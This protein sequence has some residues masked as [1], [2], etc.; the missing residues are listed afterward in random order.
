MFF[1]LL[2]LALTGQSLV[3]VS[4]EVNPLSQENVDNK[5]RVELQPSD[6]TVD[7]VESP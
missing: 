2:A 7:M 5:L 3:S 6:I 1:D 4:F